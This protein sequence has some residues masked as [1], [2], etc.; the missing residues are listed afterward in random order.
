MQSVQI[1]LNEVM[2]NEVML[3]LFQHL[4]SHPAPKST[5]PFRP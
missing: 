3:N 2:L 1:I 5:V 4:P